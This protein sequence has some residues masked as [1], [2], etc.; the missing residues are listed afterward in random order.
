ML[1]WQMA[2]SLFIPQGGGGW[3]EEMKNVDPILLVE[4]KM[5]DK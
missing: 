4:V 5:T 1:T 3:V 2:C